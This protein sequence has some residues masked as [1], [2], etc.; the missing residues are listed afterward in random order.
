[1]LA[2]LQI[3]YSGHQLAS[4]KQIVIDHTSDD[5]RIQ[6]D[7][8]LLWRVLGNMVKNALEASSA[9]DM[10]TLHCQHA[11]DTVIFGVH[12]PAFMA[13]NVQLQVFKRSFT[14]K[15]DGRGLGTYSI[16]LLTEQYLGGEVSFHSTR[17][18][19]TTFMARF[20]LVLDERGAGG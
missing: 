7:Q 1:M 8:T 2:D 13:R 20:P 19:G 5:V 17:E 14:T 15:G 3:F 16:K 9:G 12:N 4:G 11:G 18:G 6:S 10:V